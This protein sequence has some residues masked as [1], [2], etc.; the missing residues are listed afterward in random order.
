MEDTIKK[1]RWFLG[2]TCAETTWRDELMPLLDARGTDYFNPVVDDWTPECQDIEE[3]EKN[4]KCNVHLY[5]I[6]PE[7]QGVYSVAEIV[8]SAHL[9]NT[10]G[11]SVDRVI[12]VVLKSDAWTKQQ[13]KSLDATM[14]L[15]K[16]IARENCVVGFVSSMAKLVELV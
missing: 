12:F 11:T 1:D 9:A 6:T 7:M 3:D 16:N 13:V 8:H 15:V 4:N 10:Y 2:G 5:V 14:K